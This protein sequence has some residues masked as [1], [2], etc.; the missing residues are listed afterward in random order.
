MKSKVLAIYLPQFHSIPENN[1][2]WG[3]GF[4]E[5]TNVKRGRSFYPGHYQPRVPYHNDYYD[6]S[7]L[8]VL[9]RHIQTAK[10]AKIAGFAFYHYYFSGKKLLEKPIEAYRDRSKEVFPYCLI[11]ANQSWT[12]TW[13]R[14]DAGKQML[15]RQVYGGE[16]EWKKHFLYLLEFFKDNRYIKIEN[17]IAK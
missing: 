13:Y 15:L 14:A 5:W 16:E 3:E 2:W 4:T 7:N 12:R 11:W 6:L 1:A 10:V 9:E 17:K 8:R